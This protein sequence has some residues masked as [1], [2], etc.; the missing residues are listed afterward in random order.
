MK[1]T[2]DNL[3]SNL[4]QVL[5]YIKKRDLDWV[6]VNTGG[7]GSGKSSLSAAIGFYVDNSFNVNRMCLKG[8]E[9]RTKAIELDNLNSIVFDEGIENLYSRDAMKTDNKK[10][11]KFF[12][13]C[14]YLNLFIQINIPDISELDKNIRPPSDRIH[15]IARCV[16]QGWMH[17]YSQKSLKNIKYKD[18]SIKWPDYDFR[19]QFPDMSKLKPNF[20][21][22]YQKKKEEDVKNIESE[23]DNKKE[24]LSIKE[25]AKVVISEGSSPDKSDYVRNYRNRTFVD[26]DLIAANFEIGDR[27]SRKVKKL[28]EKR[29]G[30]H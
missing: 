27:A 11:I 4:D 30:L 19:G 14:R 10:M 22:A 20:W 8:K 13:K 2:S 29:L 24:E 16:N 15:S 17:F 26:Q 21:K 25:M 18:N 6:H 23:G 12:R 3:E 5:D 28:A 7:E 1:Y 9:L